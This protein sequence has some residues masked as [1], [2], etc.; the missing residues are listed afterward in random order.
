MTDESRQEREGVN[1]EVL[2]AQV[3]DFILQRIMEGQLSPGSRIVET[4]IAR[5]LGVSQ[6]P[7]REALRDL[8]SVG[9]V[10]VEPYRGAFVREPSRSELIEAMTVRRELEAIG[11]RWAA[12]QMTDDDL[13]ELR[14]LIGEMGAAAAEGDT[15][16]HALINTRF[17]QKVMEVSGNRSLI[18]LWSLLQ[19]MARTY[20]TATV[21]GVDLDWLG[22]RHLPILEALASREPELAEKA[23]RSHSEEAQ[24]LALHRH[25]I[26]EERDR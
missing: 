22:E 16:R 21:A 25:D 15:H 1:R 17:H 24:E 11:A 5:E 12:P 2:S 6:A 7:V 19:P 26:D 8:A 13:E 23:I 18:W 20:Y 14:L 10:Q 4:R 9:I 3:K